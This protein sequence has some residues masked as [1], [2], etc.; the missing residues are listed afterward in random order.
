MVENNRML[1]DKLQEQAKRLGAENLE[2]IHADGLQW[3]KN[4]T[5]RF[6]VV[7]IDPPFSQGLVE[8]ACRHLLDYGILGRGGL[9]YVESEPGLEIQIQGLEK[10]KEGKAGKVQYQLLEYR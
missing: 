4:Q 8:I 9:V 5:R 6:D 7:F 1:H 2:I 3:L 10:I